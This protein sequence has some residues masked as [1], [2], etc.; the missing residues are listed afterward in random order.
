MKEVV[1]ILE[2]QDGITTIV[3]EEEQTKILGM[4]CGGEV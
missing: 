1:E 3:V 4:V 2:K